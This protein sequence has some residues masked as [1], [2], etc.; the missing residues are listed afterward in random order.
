[1]SRKIRGASD[2]LSEDYRA[3]Q[4]ILAA[5]FEVFD[6]YGY[7]AVDVPV[8]EQT[9]LYLRKGGEEMLPSL[10]DFSF[11]NRRLC[12]RPEL[13]ASVVRLY[14]DNLQH[15]HK[16]ARLCFSGPV[17]RYERPQKDRS[18]QFTQVGV[19]MLGVK[20]VMADAEVIGLACAGLERVGISD[21]QA[22]IGHIGILNQ[23][24]NEL[25]LDGRLQR[26]LLAQ[27]ES[28][29]REGIEVSR[30]ILEKAYPELREALESGEKGAQP[31]SPRHA[32][33]ATLLRGMDRKQARSIILDIVD[34]MNLDL[35]GNR[36]PEE[37]VDR[38]LGKIDRQNQASAV[39]RAIGF[40]RELVRLKGDPAQI[41][42]EAKDLVARHGLDPGILEDFRQLIDALGKYGVA[43]RITV[44]LGM[45]RGLPYYTGIIFE[46]HQ[47]E[48][49]SGTQLCGGGR[50]DGLITTLGGKGESGAA[51]FAYGLE[52][53]RSARQ[54]DPA[55]P[56][57][58]PAV[59]DVLL[60]AVTPQEELYAVEAAS[61][62]R[63]RGVR[64]ELDVRRRSVARNLQHA[65]KH[66]F[67][68]LAIV[69][70]EE[71]AAST[72]FLKHLKSEQTWKVPANRAAEIVRA[73]E[74]EKWTSRKI[75][76]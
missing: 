70:S 76:S 6:C 69:G 14:V 28:V 16:P 52:R 3:N 18:R 25:K 53:L 9:E 45:S 54:A 39:D 27:L 30:T 67:P 64:T 43:E 68:F 61:L 71:L 38:L 24:L 44:D 49:G 13:T 50:Y 19:E 11:G 48:S 75:P 58:V 46:L 72:V 51:G 1:M 5:L 22:V 36:E 20:G 8:L 40:M 42:S 59:A 65:L 60:A 10:Y 31:E 66:N 34:E 26:M 23:F 47:N 33:I 12:L 41:L 17:F 2:V 21:Y 57:P 62:L 56:P 15:K 73:K 7:C 35:S 4:E 32:G 29:R 74:P 63:R 55:N 37:I